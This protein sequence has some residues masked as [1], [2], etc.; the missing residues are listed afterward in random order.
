MLDAAKQRAYNFLNHL[1]AQR[2]RMIVP[3]DRLYEWQLAEGAGP[4]FNPMSLPHEAGLYLRS[5]NPRLI[6]LERRYDKCD[7]AVT[8][9]LVWHRDHVSAAT[10]AYFRGDR[11]E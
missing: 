10:L 8:A 9:P 1:L 5:D 11:S 4:S 3:C 7:P 2:G 6:E